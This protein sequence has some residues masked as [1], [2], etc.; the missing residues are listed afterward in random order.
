M[1]IASTRTS[2]IE[3]LVAMAS[4]GVHQMLLVFLELDRKEKRLE[5]YRKR[6]MLEMEMERTTSNGEIKNN[7]SPSSS[8]P[9]TR[10]SDASEHHE[11]HPHHQHHQHHEHHQHHQHHQ[12]HPHHPH[13]PHHRHHQHHND[14]YADKDILSM[15]DTWMKNIKEKENT[16]HQRVGTIHKGRAQRYC[17]KIRDLAFSKKGRGKS[18]V[19]ISRTISLSYNFLFLQFLVLTISFLVIFFLF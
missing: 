11:G 5:E 1:D 3:T 12:H 16:M 8:H 4:H 18:F 13:H 15:L 14:P 19:T 7:E 17:N 6:K 10:D 9:T 2:K